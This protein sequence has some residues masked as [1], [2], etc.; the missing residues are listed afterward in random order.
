MLLMPDTPVTNIINLLRY[1]GSFKSFL[2]I[3]LFHALQLLHNMLIWMIE[4]LHQRPKHRS[5]GDLSADELN[6]ITS[7]LNG[8]LRNTI[9]SLRLT[10][11]ILVPYA[12]ETLFSEAHLFLHPASLAKIEHF[13]TDITKLVIWLL[14]FDQPLRVFDYYAYMGYSE[15]LRYIWDLHRTNGGSQYEE[16]TYVS[17]ALDPSHRLGC[18]SD[19]YTTLKPCTE[20]TFNQWP[21]ANAVLP[22]IIRWLVPDLAAETAI[23]VKEYAILD[24]DFESFAY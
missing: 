21:M 15:S 10:Q 5:L 2:R 9:K 4:Y 11:R 1:H 6:I 8:S 19:A 3:E 17:E 24:T 16:L 20:T 23:V 13:A 18:Q 7:H 12:N 22:D 14:V